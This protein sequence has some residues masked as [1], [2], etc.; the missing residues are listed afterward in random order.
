MSAKLDF[1]YFAQNDVQ[2]VTN[3]HI[4]LETLTLLQRRVSMDAVWDFKHKFIR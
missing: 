4:L 1:E 3:S 2:P